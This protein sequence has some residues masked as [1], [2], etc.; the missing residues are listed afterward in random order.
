MRDLIISVR[1]PSENRIYPCGSPEGTLMK[2]LIG[3]SGRAGETNIPEHS[4]RNHGGNLN[5]SKVLKEE[6][7]SSG[8]GRTVIHQAK[9]G[10][11]A[12]LV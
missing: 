9:R 4:R 5:R 11:E 7:E 3:R 12:I 6:P 1:I 10:Q 8:S 2:L